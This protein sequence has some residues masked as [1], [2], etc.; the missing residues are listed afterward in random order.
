MQLIDLIER[1]PEH[2][3]QQFIHKKHKKNSY[4][5]HPNEANDYLYIVSKGKAEV[6]SQNA[7]GTMISLFHYS[8]Y[9]LFGELE[10]FK[11]T[12]TTF[13][14]IAKSDCEILCLHKPYVLE[15]LQLD[16]DFN[17]Y[18]YD[19]LCDKLLTN[20]D[21]A[22]KIVLQT[23]KERLLCSINAHDKIGD[24][25][26]L[27]KHV[28]ASEVCTTLR[29]LNRTIAT[30]IEEGYITYNNKRFNI[31]SHELLDDFMNGIEY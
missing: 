19:Q 15:W 13:S 26:Q 5:L 1:A 6:Y 29:S 22:S 20:A 30:C 23:V 21:I 16:F 14:V 2:I 8:A 24:L 28:L 11:Q 4:I 18:M 25:N 17:L 31:V 3:K 10:I 12:S 9:S 27:T 7:H